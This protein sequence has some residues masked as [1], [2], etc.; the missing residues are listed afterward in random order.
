M[1]KFMDIERIK[2]KYATAFSVGENIV[3]EEKIDGANASFTY[4]T[5]TDSVVS[6]SRNMALKPS[7]T[8]QGFYN[9][10]GL[11]DKEV[12]KSVTLNGRYII[13]GEWLCL[14]GDTIIKKVSS[15]K[16]KSEMTLKEMYEYAHTPEK[17]R[18]KSWWE[19]NGYPS[20]YSLDLETDM[21][22]PNKMQEIVYTGK[23]KVYKLT[24]H[25][26]YSIKATANHPFLTPKGW[27]E[28][29]KL[30]EYDC[31]AITDFITKNTH[32]RTYGVGT[33]EIFRKQ[34]E[35]KD[36]IGKCEVCGAT[37]GLNL[38]HKDENPFNNTE[39]NWQVLCQDCHGNSHTKFNNQPKFDYE[40]DYIISI[41]DVGEEDCYDICMSGNENI[42]NFIAN[43]FIVHNC[44][45]T[46]KYPEDCYNNFYMFDVWD[47]VDEC[48]LPFNLVKEMYDML[49]ALGINIRF[50]PVFYI[51]KFTSWEDIQKMVGR[52]EV[53]AE[54]CG[55]GVVVKT[56]DRLNDK[57][58]RTPKYLKIV[59]E[60]FSEVQSHKGQRKPV[61]PEVL[62]RKEEERQFVA[63]IVTDR[64]I[65]K[66]LEKLVD[67]GI[68]PVDWDEHNMKDIAKNLP[69]L[70][71]ADCK[72]EEPEDVAKVE[73]FGKICGSL[74]MNR[75]KE[76]LKS[77]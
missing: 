47:T 6:F 28:L 22:Q 30:S 23:K 5:E 70:V 34:K 4:D 59:T 24:T 69:S 76:L 57:T 42:A 49:V 54:P 62:K 53:G 36:K 50:V 77:R 48:Y 56:I 18:T 67:E 17:G 10:V 21:I 38:H 43:N 25:K 14:S 73:N 66:C 60:R 40:F 74:T 35:Y 29:G 8:L 41:E 55:E 45:H 39:D 61:D 72:K 32:Q 16:G 12:I 65:D 27:V 7:N 52:T 13:F 11:F 31:V 20:L 37:N 71:Y 2:E 26:G 3:C 63:T 44:K 58:D 15:G 1:K 46:I 9:F 64:R 68:L 51:G 19:R 75:V 33:R